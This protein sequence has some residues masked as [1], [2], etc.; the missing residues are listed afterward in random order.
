[1]QNETTKKEG[2][3]KKTSI[4][5]FLMKQEVSNWP[6]KK[7][8]LPRIIYVYIQ[9]FRLDSLLCLMQMELVCHAVVLLLACSTKSITISVC[10]NDKVFPGIIWNSDAI[11]K[12]MSGVLHNQLPSM[13]DAGVQCWHN[14]MADSS[15]WNFFEVRKV[16]PHFS[17]NC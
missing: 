10:S 15:E 1:M 12:A 13:C 4:L 6:P 3:Y 17:N 9:Y 11:S 7:A 5:L 16:S 2:N 8:F 14:C